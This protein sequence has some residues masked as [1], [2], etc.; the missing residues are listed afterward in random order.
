M[1]IPPCMGKIFKIIVFTFQE[2]GLNLGIFTHASV[3]HSKLQA[4]FFENLFPQ[5]AE[6]CGENYDLL[7]QNS[8]RKNEDDLE[9]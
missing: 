4:E 6:R 2:S 1:Y 5:T 7:Y 9:H 8:V 3:P